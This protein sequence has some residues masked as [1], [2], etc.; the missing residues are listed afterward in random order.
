MSR[1]R[2][3]LTLTALMRQQQR[4][5][6]PPA[7]LVARPLRSFW[8][9]A[10]LVVAAATLAFVLSAHFQLLESFY[11]LTRRWE[12]L[13]LDEL[14][15]G[16]LVLAVGLSWLAWRRYR[17]AHQELQARCAAEARLAAVLADNRRLAQESLRIQESERKHL[18]RELHDQLGQYL[19]AI[20]L[21][22]LALGA[23]GGCEAAQLARA[24]AA[25]VHNVDHV[26]DTVR[27]MIG[28]LRP[29]ALDELGLGAAIEHCVD[30]W[31]RHLPQIRFDCCLDNDLDELG[32]PLT[33]TLYR[34]V[35]EA[36]TNIGKHA[37]AHCVQIVLER[38]PQ[39][40]PDQLLLVISDDG[41]GMDVEGGLRGFGL[42]GMRERVAMAGGLFELR[43]SPGHGVRITVRMPLRVPG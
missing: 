31:R 34:L 33:L 22:T 4:P 20:K 5:C 1:L 12:Y 32:E 8:R 9:D 17:Q 43:S 21:D 29:V 15:S 37:D 42:S 41:R 18:A 6:A 35:Q 2:P 26:Y 25:I 36:L 23:P 28:R 13:Q 16:L 10:A 7:T 24:S 27:Q 39:P 40:R 30:Q 19:N 3:G 38:Q 11:A 14:S